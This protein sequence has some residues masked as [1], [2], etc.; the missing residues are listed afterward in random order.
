MLSKASNLMAL[1]AIIIAPLFSVIL[2]KNITGMLLTAHVELKDAVLLGS[3]AM[4]AAAVYSAQ[5]LRAMGRWLSPTPFYRKIE[6]R[7]IYLV[8]GTVITRNGFDYV[9]GW[10]SSKT[11]PREDL[12]WHKKITKSDLFY[13]FYERGKLR[14]RSMT[15]D[16]RT[17]IDAVP[18]ENSGSSGGD[19]RYSWNPTVH[20]PLG[21]KESISFMVEI[22]SVRT[23][24]AAFQL[25]TK[26]GF[27]VNIPTTRAR[28]RAHAPFGYR[29]VLLDPQL[30]VRRSDTLEEVAVPA[31][32]RPTPNVS[33][34]GS[35][36]TLEVRRPMLNRRY[37]VHYRF[38]SL[39]V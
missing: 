29:F 17:T 34:D 15:S 12:I 36:L 9:N 6:L 30:T 37:W 24:T 14:D 8:D 20:P 13:R 38:E 22:M 3:I 16:G 7:Y 11:L 26:L 19:Y 1:L 35:S 32:R 4:L 23:E 39:K 21:I 2:P 10:K 25:G 27:G 5:I 33:E 28:L 31:S 18:H